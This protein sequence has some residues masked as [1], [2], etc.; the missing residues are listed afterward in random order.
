MATQS[1]ILNKVSEIATSQKYEKTFDFVR[2]FT[3]RANSC[4]SFTIPI[5]T[6]GPFIQL[7]INIR[8]TKNSIKHV[9]PEDPTTDEHFC[10]VKIRF[11]SQSQGN[12]QS[13]D[14]IPV[15]LIGTPLHDDFPRY[16]ARPFFYY[17]PK[18]DALIIEYDNRAPSS[19]NGETY[20][21]ANEQVDVCFNGKLYPLGF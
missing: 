16:G 1:E 18:G 5:T 11:K 4:E 12:A 8:V 3:A 7:S 14:F 2:S 9:D 20:T 19:L 15:Q 6:E 17:Y 13:S 21:M 10:G